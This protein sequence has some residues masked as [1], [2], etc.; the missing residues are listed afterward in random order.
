M[1]QNYLR[2]T[3]D[4]WAKIFAVVRETKLTD[5]NEDNPNNDIMENILRGK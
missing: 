4:V 2:Q 5:W 3:N 1:A